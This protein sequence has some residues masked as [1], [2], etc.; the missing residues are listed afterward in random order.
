[1]RNRES[2]VV[3]IN[4]LVILA[5]TASVVH[6]MISLSEQAITRSQR[7]SAAGQAQ[8]LISAGEA[9]AITALRRDMVEA[10]QAD[11]EGEPWALVGQ[12]PV[13][14]EGGSF[15][16]RIE[17]AQAKFNL[18]SLPISGVLGLQILQRIVAALEMS[19]DVTS[20][21]AARMTRPA[22]LER[23]S[24]LVAE[25]GL[26]TL[27]VAELAKLVTALPGRTPINISTAPPALLA[28]LASNPVQARLLEGA[29]TRQGFLTPDDVA[30]AQMVLPPG[31][32]FASRFFWMTVT[33]E[34]DGTRQTMRSLL[35][36]G[37]AA[38]GRPV[39]LVIARERADLP[40][41]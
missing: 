2:G 19:P 30:D 14:I 12:T 15:A 33:V 34:L 32:G 7:F 25:A 13:P 8:A 4:V 29:R 17:D 9:S 21:I 16:L 28:A 26:T 24:D 11:H 36:R 40:E 18:N 3:L 39:V 22:E 27:E 41:L 37:A 20:R 31:A 35:Q 23:L 5:L 1:M 10:G 38:N 6:V